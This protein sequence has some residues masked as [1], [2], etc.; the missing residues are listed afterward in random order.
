MFAVQSLR[1]NIEWEVGC[2]GLL[3]SVFIILISYIHKLYSD[4]TVTLKI[5]V[6]TEV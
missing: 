2:T 5:K 4:M 3:N 6:Y 1:R